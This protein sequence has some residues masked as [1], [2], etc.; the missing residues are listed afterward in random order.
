[1]TRA[2]E[3]RFPAL[4]MTD[5]GN[6]FG[7]IQFYSKAMKEGIK[8]ILGCEVY[9]A[10]GSRLSKSSSPGETAN[11]LVLLAETKASELHIRGAGSHFNIITQAP[12]DFP[13]VPTLEAEPDFTIENGLLRRMIEWTVFASEKAPPSTMAVPRCRSFLQD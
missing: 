10:P 7:A 11:H 8:P 9:V 13:A 6:L 12:T 1:M 2:K 3:L 5:N 4:A